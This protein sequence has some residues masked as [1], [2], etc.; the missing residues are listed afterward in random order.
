MVRT[1]V[2]LTEEERE[3]LDRHSISLTKLVKNILKERIDEKGEIE[4]GKSSKH[5]HV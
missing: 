3:Y 2:N 5:R 1:T 4:N